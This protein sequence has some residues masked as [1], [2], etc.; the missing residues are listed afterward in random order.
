MLAP[1]VQWLYW[2]GGMVFV[3]AYI[4][5]NHIYG[6]SENYLPLIQYSLAGMMVMYSVSFLTYLISVQKR[7]VV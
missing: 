3:F 7:N 5:V 1:G 4:I 6:P 2:P